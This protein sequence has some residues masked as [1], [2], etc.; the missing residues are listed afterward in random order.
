MIENVFKKIKEDKEDE[1][2]NNLIFL[3]AKNLFCESSDSI[4]KETKTTRKYMKE[5]DAFEA[6][7]IGIK[8]LIIGTINYDC[9]RLLTDLDFK[10]KSIVKGVKLI[11]IKLKRQNVSERIIDVIIRLLFNSVPSECYVLYNQ[12][13]AYNN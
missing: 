5:I 8:E 6:K 1:L 11:E 3:V 4:E 10:E 12:N 2:K 9:N 7:I 13:I